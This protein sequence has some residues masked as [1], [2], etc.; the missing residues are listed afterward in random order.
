VGAF[1]QVADQPDDV[2]GDGRHRQPFHR[3]LQLE[4]QVLALVHGGQQGLA[5]LLLLDLD[6]RAQQ[7]AHARDALRQGVLPARGPLAGA[8]R[9][10]QTPVHELANGLHAGQAR[11][12]DVLN[13][14]VH[15]LKVRGAGRK[16]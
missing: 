11:F 12:G 14:R 5:A 2:V 15:Q 6:P 16:A 10:R 7:V 1:G 13:T 4:L 9:G 8:A 3:G